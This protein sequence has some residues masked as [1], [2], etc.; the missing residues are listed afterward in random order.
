MLVP[1]NGSGVSYASESTAAGINSVK[2]S[3]FSSPAFSTEGGAVAAWRA[4]V[5]AAADF[6][7]SAC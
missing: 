3:N 6:I 4:D 1:L 2:V 7:Q 5:P